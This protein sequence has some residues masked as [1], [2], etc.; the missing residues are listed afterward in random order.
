M[1]CGQSKSKGDNRVEKAPAS[2]G[3][4]NFLGLDTEFARI[5]LE[6]HRK[7]KVVKGE[8]RHGNKVDKH[9][10]DEVMTWAELVHGMEGAEKDEFGR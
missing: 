5:F 2:G 4:F 1:G 7:K 10:H 8:D 9:V 6:K 3:H